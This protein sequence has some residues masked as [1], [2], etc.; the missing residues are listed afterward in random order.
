MPK[1]FLLDTGLLLSNPAALY[2]FEENNVYITEETISELSE[3]RRG[4]GP[5]STHA[6]E[7]LRMIAGYAENNHTLPGGGQLQIVKQSRYAAQNVAGSSGIIKALKA[8][9]AVNQNTILVTN[10]S[11]AHIWAQEEGLVAEPFFREQVPK[12]QY[13]GRRDTYAAADVI[14]CLHDNGSVPADAVDSGDT[15]FVEN[16][17]LILHNCAAPNETT[18]A[19]YSKREIHLLPR[20]FTAYGV[21]PRNVGQRFAL[22]ALLAPVEEIPLVILKGPAG[23]A[24]TYLALAAGLQQVIEDNLFDNILVSRPNI[25][26]DND[27]GFLKG[28]EEDK[29]GPLIRPVIDNLNQLCRMSQPVKRGT[30]NIVNYV[31]DIFSQG[32]VVAQ[33]M[34]Y[35]RGRSIS[36]TYILIDECQNMNQAQAFGIATRVGVGSKVI[37]AGDPEQIDTPDLDERNNGL[38]FVSEMMRGSP[39]CAQITFSAEECVR[40]PLALEAIQRLKTN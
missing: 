28:T 6:Q 11:A 18:L 2:S 5:Q 38:S 3:K 36:N 22:H 4:H 34:A 17:Y 39:L 16:E 29:V 24:K 31:Q 37:L 32:L 9:S 10:D 13:T 23:T 15:P 14:S 21:K 26:F 1:Q 40:S 27:I 7:V 8:L 33:A 20:G 30:M 25:K 12:E 19:R 35:M